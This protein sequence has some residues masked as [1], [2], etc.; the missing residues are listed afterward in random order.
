MPATDPHANELSSWVSIDRPEIV[1]RPNSREPFKAAIHVP[2]TATRGERYGAIWAEVSSRTP[3]AGNPVQLVNKIGV[4][5]YLDAGPGGDPPSD[6]VIEELMPGRTEEGRPVVKAT[7]RNTG[8]RALDMSGHLWLSDGPGGLKAGP[9][10][11]QVGTT[12]AINDGAPV[13]VVLDARLLDGPWNVELTLSS[14]LV[15]R[16]VSG[17]LT[18]PEKS[19]SWGLPALLHDPVSVMVIVV[20]VA[21]S[22]MGAFLLVC[23]ICLDTPLVGQAN[24]RVM[25]QYRGGVRQQ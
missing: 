11:A 5:I 13:M 20:L 6:F 25:G 10:R 18:F 7:V 1:V 12:F 14:G 9:F 4:R 16:T 3:G 24:Q 15:K 22:A 2:E 19:A 23:A 21:A 8:E 17:T